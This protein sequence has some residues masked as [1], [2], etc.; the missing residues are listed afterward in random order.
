MSNQ[1]TKQRLDQTIR[2]LAPIDGVSID[3]FG[4]SATCRIDFQVAATAPQRT[5]AQN[6]LTAFDWSDGAETTWED[7]QQPDLATLR[8][9]A[10]GAVQNNNAYVAIADSATNIQVRDQV[11]A[12]TQQNTQII[13]SLGA[14]IQLLT[15][16]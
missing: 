9:A 6:A 4:N 13:K 12:L 1:Q 8:N 14:V 2:A 11:K 10:V 5:A 15:G 7:T 3:A 16:R